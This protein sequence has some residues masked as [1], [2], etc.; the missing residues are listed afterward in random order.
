MNKN[1]LLPIVVGGV[2]LVCVFAANANQ[3]ILK[4]NLDIER[5]NRLDAERKL[6]ATMKNTHR[7]QDEL[8]EA[9]EKL[10]GIQDIVSEGQSASKQLK[11][12]AEAQARENEELKQSIKKLQDE[13]AA[14]QKVPT[15]QP[16]IAA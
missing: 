1:I 15:D 14:S 6:E 10:A 4:K 12:Q 5:F 7:I 3:T 16:A 9:K 2:A 13:L 8:A 11:S